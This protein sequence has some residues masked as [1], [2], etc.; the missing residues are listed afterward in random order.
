MNNVISHLERKWL[1]YYMVSASLL[2]IANLPGIIFG[3]KTP[4]EIFN[5]TETLKILVTPVAGL[6]LF[7]SV[8]GAL[9]AKI[10]SIDSPT[11]DAN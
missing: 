4:I 2:M 3:I 10:R 9:S 8:A 5:A 1:M 7:L 11:N 6:T